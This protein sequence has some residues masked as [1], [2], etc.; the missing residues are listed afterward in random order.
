M[1]DHGKSQPAALGGAN[2]LVTLEG[3]KGQHKFCSYPRA[4]YPTSS[5]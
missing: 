3:G 1:R 2:E 5:V 4:S